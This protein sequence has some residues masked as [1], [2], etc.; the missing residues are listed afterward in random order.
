MWSSMTSLWCD[1]NIPLVLLGISFSGAQSILIVSLLI[2]QPPS[3][4]LGKIP[5]ETGILVPM[6]MEKPD[7]QSELQAI[8]DIEI[9]AA[10]YPV[11]H[12]N[13]PLAHDI[14]ANER[15][16]YAIHV[17]FQGFKY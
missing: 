3:M 8:R 5:D 13:A 2:C 14:I 10:G 16:L 11:F 17:K 9:P 4:K 6:Y 12:M 1:V 7:A 15:C